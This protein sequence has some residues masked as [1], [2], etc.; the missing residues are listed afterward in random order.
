MIYRSKAPLRLGLAGGG[1]DVS[2]YSD[3]Y[4]GYVMNATIDMYAYCTLEIT[5]DNTITFHALD[6]NEYFECS[7]TK[8]IELEG[9]LLLHKGIYNRIIKQFNNNMPLSVKVTTYS[10]V[11][12][13]SGLG[14]SSTMVVAILKAY[15]EALSLPLGDYELAHLAY[16]I[17]RIDIGINGGKQDQ[18]AATF[19][20]FNFL[21]FHEDDRVI[22]NPLR[23][24]NWIINELE[25]SLVL[26]Y[27]GTS[28]DSSRIIEEQT[29]NTL[30]KKKQSLAA[31]HKLKE[32]AVLM[33]EAILKG[34][35]KLFAQ[36]LGESWNSKKNVAA[37]I[38]NR[39]ID[40]VYNTAMEAGA[41]AGKV[42]GAGGG[43]FM[44]FIVD[45]LDK[46]E[47]VN[48]LKQFD[49]GIYNVHFVKYGCQGW[50]V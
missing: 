41:L 17:E 23:I 29:I 5:E 7:L 21:E 2:P 27:T 49:G 46:L 45:P 11:P 19:G 9:S 48:T 12:A 32:H 15:A 14:S 1:T 10:D 47:V 24:K 28:R 36:Y 38:S 42:S 35:I 8:E 22:V 6:L 39:Y 34:D 20:G 31:L 30:K 50:K 43:G 37:P 44:M 26:F 33:K 18:Y 40:L 16:E 3:V 25:S 13:G 4:G